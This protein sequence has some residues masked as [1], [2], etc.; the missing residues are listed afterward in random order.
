MNI[1]SI[2]R[3]NQVIPVSKA[4]ATLPALIETVS[5]K[6]FYI[7]AKKYKPKAALVDLAFLEKLLLVY[8]NW[9]VKQDFSKLDELRSS[10]PI[11]KSTEVERDIKNALANVRSN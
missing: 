1:S 6:D 2:A 3:A 4:R 10:I 11:Y 7:L 9:R 8:N 5:K